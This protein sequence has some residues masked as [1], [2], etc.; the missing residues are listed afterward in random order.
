M[1]LAGT[2]SVADGSRMICP[3]FINED[4]QL[5]YYEGCTQSL[6]VTN[7]FVSKFRG[8]FLHAALNYP[9]SYHDA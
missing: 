1:A 3:S 2:I 8:E 6:E 4:L 9:G 7:L 5:A